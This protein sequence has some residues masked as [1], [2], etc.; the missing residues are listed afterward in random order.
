[1]YLGKFNKFEIF[2]KGKK[3]KLKLEENLELIATEYFKFIN[4]QLYKRQ[5]VYDTEW[6]KS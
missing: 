1:M 6:V 5:K 4:E 3:T 2:Y